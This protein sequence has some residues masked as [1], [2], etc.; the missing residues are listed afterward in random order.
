PEH[1]LTNPAND[2][3]ARFIEG[4]DMARVL[5]AQNAMRPVRATAREGDGPRTVLRNMSENCLDS[6][7]ITTRDRRLLGLID[8]AALNRAIQDKKETVADMIDPDVPTI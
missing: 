2:Y 3:V 8:A 6:I 4:V 7:Y 1:I 5:T